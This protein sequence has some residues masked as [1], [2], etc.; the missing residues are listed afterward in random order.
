M[1]RKLNAFA[2]LSAALVAGL[3]C[4]MFFAKDSLDYQKCL[5][6]QL[7]FDKQVPDY[8]DEASYK[9]IKMVLNVE[10]D[11]LTHLQCQV[12]APSRSVELMEASELKQYLYQHPHDSLWCEQLAKILWYELKINQIKSRYVAVEGPNGR[13]SFVECALVRDS[14]KL[15]WASFQPTSS[16]LMPL[17]RT[18]KFSKVL[19]V[20]DLIY[21]CK[22]GIDLS[23]QKYLMNK[24]CNVD[25]AFKDLK[26]FK[27]VEKVYVYRTVPKSKIFYKTLQKLSLIPYRTVYTAHP[28]NLGFVIKIVIVYGLF[29]GS[30]LLLLISKI[31]WII[32]K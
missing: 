9:K 32:K 13:H 31:L 15:F 18:A 4:Y 25:R 12:G 2:Q 3:L 1:S 6:E 23:S 29:L 14:G 16:M 20:F 22:Y 24:N 8:F 17:Y 30:L 11:V 7:V 10:T 27:N 5:D 26:Y 19:S 28:S 21:C